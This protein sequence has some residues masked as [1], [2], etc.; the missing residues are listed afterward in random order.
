S[1]ETPVSHIMTREVLCITPDYSLQE[2]MAIMSGKK[3]R[4]L[5]VLDEDKKLSGIISIGDV[6][7]A[8][9]EEQKVEIENL[10]QY[11][12]SSYPG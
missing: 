2:C 9:M 6:V 10:R 3:I 11:I 1:K 5:P 7:K 12:S 4:H 8:V